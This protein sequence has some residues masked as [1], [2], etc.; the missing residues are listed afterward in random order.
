M[1]LS[2]RVNEN[3]LKFVQ[4]IFGQTVEFREKLYMICAVE[5]NRDA[6]QTLEDLNSKLQS[7]EFK[8]FS[9]DV[10][11]NDVQ[12]S[13]MLTIAKFINLET[14][15]KISRLPIPIDFIIDHLDRCTCGKEFHVKFGSQKYLVP[16]EKMTVSEGDYSSGVIKQRY[17][18]EMTEYELKEYFG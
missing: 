11:N 7:K 2:A 10:H 5:M 4:A 3:E 17:E 1:V 12:K 13:Y 18:F 6:E 9:C 8:L 15:E 14:F 16:R